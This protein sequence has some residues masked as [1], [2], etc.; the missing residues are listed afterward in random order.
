M[1]SREEQ[2]VRILIEEEYPVS[3]RLLEAKLVKWGYDVIV[4]SDGFEE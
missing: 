1:S 2:A 4:T 3:R